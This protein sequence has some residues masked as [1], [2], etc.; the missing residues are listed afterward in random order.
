MNTETK[1]SD[2]WRNPNPVPMTD[3]PTEVKVH[4][5]WRG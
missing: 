3:L 1:V 2:D 5:N 4:N